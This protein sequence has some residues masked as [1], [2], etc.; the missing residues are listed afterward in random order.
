MLTHQLPI[1]SQFK[2]MLVDNLNA[3]IVLGTVTNIKEAVAW[4]SYTYLYIR[5]VKNPLV[6]GLTYQDLAVS[7]DGSCAGL[8]GQPSG[9][10]TLTSFMKVVCH[11]ELMCT[12]IGEMQYDNLHSLDKLL[13]ACNGCWS[14]QTW[15]VTLVIEHA[16]LMLAMLRSPPQMDPTL[17]AHK[18]A[19]VTQAAA[20]LK[21]SQM[22][23]FDEKSG[24][25]YVT[26][27]GR[28]ASHYYVR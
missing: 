4:L 6:Y 16:G 28:V 25:L 22:A 13:V 7:V 27:L 9:K 23:V 24:N 18:R 14:I 12:M 11:V 3:E 15:F 8:V 17:E 10:C 2:A 19:L 5:M 26:E 20:Q 1:E 21:E